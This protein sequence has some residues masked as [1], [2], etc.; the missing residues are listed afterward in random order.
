MK[1]LRPVRGAKLLL[2]MI[3]EGEHVSQDFKYT[4]TDAR[5]IARSISAFANNRGGRLLIGVKDNGTIAGVRNQE[6]IFV[7]EQAASRY[8][9]PPQEIDFKAYRFQGDIYVIVASVA[10]A[11]SRPVTVIEADGCGKAYFRVG[12]ENI[13]AH[14]LMVKAWRLASGSEPIS[15]TDRH[16][17]AAALYSGSS[18]PIDVRSAA[19][20]LHISLSDAE[21]IIADLAATDILTFAFDGTAF[22]PVAK[23]MC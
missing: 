22:T 2:E 12:D 21:N 13:A 7:V 20:K 9:T 18:T 16:Y 17:A 19:L 23:Q 1:D 15:L 3:K 8:C 4:I 14:P 10:P 11:P 5:K 6:D